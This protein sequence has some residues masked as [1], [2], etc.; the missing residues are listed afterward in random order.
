MFRLTKDGANLGTLVRKARDWDSTLLVIKDGNGAVFGALIT[1]KIRMGSE[2]YY[3]SGSICVFDFKNHIFT[4]YPSAN[5]NSYYMITTF[6]LLAFGGG[7]NFAIL[8][9]GDLNRGSSGECLT[10]SSPCLSSSS[11]F[12]C[13]DCELYGFLSPFS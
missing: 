11:P 1:E 6:N 13:I 9:D 7:G 3:G 4:L 10:F 12:T 2:K 5:L 8:L